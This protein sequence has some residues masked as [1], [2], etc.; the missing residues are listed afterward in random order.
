VEKKRTLNQ[1]RD[2]LGYKQTNKQTDAD[3]VN[4]I[5]GSVTCCHEDLNTKSSV[6]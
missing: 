4:A 6:V 1:I 2:T 3:T 5:V